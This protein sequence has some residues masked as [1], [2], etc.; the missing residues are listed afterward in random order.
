MKKY[1]MSVLVLLTFATVTYAAAYQI[2]EA[3]TLYSQGNYNSAL[4]KVTEAIKTTSKNDFTA[5]TLRSEIYA[6][7]N[8]TQEA[9]SDL[10][11]AIKLNSNNTNLYMSRGE[12]YYSIEKYEEALNDFIKGT[13]NFNN[14]QAFDRVKKMVDDEDVPTKYR[15]NAAMALSDRYSHMGKAYFDDHR[16]CCIKTA[17]I[18]ANTDSNDEFFDLQSKD[19]ALKEVRDSIEKTMTSNNSNDVL[20]NVKSE[21]YYGYVE[22]AMG[23]K[24]KGQKIAKG[25]I[26]EFITRYPE[27]AA[28]SITLQ[29]Y[30]SKLKNVADYGLSYN[31]QKPIVNNVGKVINNKNVRNYSRA[32]INITGY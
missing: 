27:A 24:T 1:L 9:I 7:M 15:V 29:Q 21:I 14:T 18:V 5:Y 4:N 6:K 13:M 19:S 20:E 28:Y 25:A 23:E 32:L 16:M 17:Q 30:S 10:S 11:T 12:L 26:K 3:R 22:Y 2:Q 8:K 31:G